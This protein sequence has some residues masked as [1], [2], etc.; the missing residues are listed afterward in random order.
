M[1]TLNLQ[2]PL[3]ET[4]PTIPLINIAEGKYV[5]AAGLTGQTAQLHHMQQHQYYQP[6]P[7][8]TIY[9]G[10]AFQPTHR[11]THCA[12]T[13]QLQHKQIRRKMTSIYE[14]M[15][16]FVPALDADVVWSAT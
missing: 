8:C 6:C 12:H 1:H 10:R 14:K 7:S 2:T 15:L 11:H 9:K 5:Y 4:Y 3:A 13:P 16:M